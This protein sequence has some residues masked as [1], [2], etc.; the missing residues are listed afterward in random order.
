MKKKLELTK[1]SITVLNGDSLDNLR[2]GGFTAGCTDGLHCHTLWNCTRADCTN[3]C[4]PGGK[5]SN[6]CIEY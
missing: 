4:P 5:T 1:E 6:G 2:G 3:D